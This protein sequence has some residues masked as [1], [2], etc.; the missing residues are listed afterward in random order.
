[1]RMF[2]VWKV[3]PVTDEVTVSRRAILYVEKKLDQTCALS[4]YGGGQQIAQV[5]SNSATYLLP[6]KY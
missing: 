6:V 4:T 2:G 3:V 1:M 5:L